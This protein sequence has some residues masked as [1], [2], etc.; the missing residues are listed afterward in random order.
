MMFIQVVVTRLYYLRLIFHT[1]FNT[2]TIVSNLEFIKIEF[3][4][5]S[6]L[7]HGIFLTKSCVRFDI[8]EKVQKIINSLIY[9]ERNYS[10]WSCLDFVFYHNLAVKSQTI[11][12]LSTIFKISG[13]RNCTLSTISGSRN[14]LLH[15]HNVWIQIQQYFCGFWIQKLHPFY[16]F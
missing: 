3:G 15:F 10:R 5:V 7:P 12:D 13:S 2:Q 14:L 8:Q 1:G 9:S 11:K 6:F 16:N 4:L